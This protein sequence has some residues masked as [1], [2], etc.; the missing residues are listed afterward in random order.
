MIL[1]CNNKSII[2]IAHNPIQHTKHIEIDL[3]FIKEKLASGLSTTSYVPSG[4]Q[5]GDL[6]QKL[7]PLN[8]FMI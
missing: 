1:Y 4:L 8:D 5:L 3:H 2:S 7:F 6:L